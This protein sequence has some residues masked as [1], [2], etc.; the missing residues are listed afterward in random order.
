[1]SQVIATVQRALSAAVS[2]KAAV[3]LAL[4]LNTL[5]HVIGS[6]LIVPALMVTSA[7]FSLTY[8]RAAATIPPFAVHQHL[9]RLRLSD[10]GLLAWLG[11]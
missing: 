11:H 6:V 8:L 9:G 10:W 5:L 1:V 4:L 2:R 3:L 7:M